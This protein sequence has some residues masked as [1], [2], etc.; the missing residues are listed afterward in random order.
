MF[1][2]VMEVLILWTVAA[3]AAGFVLG[4]LIGAAERVRKDEFLEAIFSNL[5]SR[6][7]AR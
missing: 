7:M 5:A 3:V 2:L 6:Q 1:L 4:A